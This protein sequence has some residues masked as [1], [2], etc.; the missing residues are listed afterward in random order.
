MSYLN[1]YFNDE[2]RSQHALNSLITRIGRNQDNDVVIDN[3]GV[4]GNHAEIIKNGSKYT[5]YDLNSTNGVFVNGE[6]ITDKELKLGD[7]IAI[8]K[9]TLRFVAV[10]FASSVETA[11]AKSRAENSNSSNSATVEVDVSKLDDLLK[12]NV[13]KNA[14][15]IVSSGKLAGRQFKLTKS[16]F[17]FG[18]TQ[19][20][21]FQVGGWFAPKIAAK[22]VRQSDGF[23]LAPEKRGKVKLNG[24]PVKNRA[25]IKGGCVIEVR[26]TTFHF[27]HETLGR[28]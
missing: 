21:D 13:E 28:G 7:E 27:G 20:C 18:K 9:H 19:D 6:R 23:Y 11:T 16:R 12:E 3:V 25:K 5:I 17:S 26:G 2:L 4:S 22:I 24:Q 15:L 1:V 10:N 8:F 14:F